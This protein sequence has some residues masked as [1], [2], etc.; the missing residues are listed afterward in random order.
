MCLAPCIEAHSCIPS[1][2]HFTDCVPSISYFIPSHTHKALRCCKA[3]LLTG[4]LLSVQPSKHVVKHIR[5]MNIQVAICIKSFKDGCV[6]EKERSNFTV[7]A[8]LRVSSLNAQCKMNAAAVRWGG[9]GAL[10]WSPVLAAFLKNWAMSSFL[11]VSCAMDLFVFEKLDGSASGRIT[12][13]R[14]CGGLCQKR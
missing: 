3:L 2:I 1:L 4:L 8:V 10:I 12:N 9:I 5:R 14:S 7:T 11:G 6:L 13:C